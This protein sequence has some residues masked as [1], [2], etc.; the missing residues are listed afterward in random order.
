ML[1]MMLSLML[2]WQ[3]VML[4]IC[5]TRNFVSLRF[6]SFQEFC[7]L[8]VITPDHHTSSTSQSCRRH[9]TRSWCTELRQIRNETNI[10]PTWNTVKHLY[11]LFIIYLESCIHVCV[12]V[13]YLHQ[14]LFKTQCLGGRT[15]VLSFGFEP[16]A[17]VGVVQL[18]QLFVTGKIWA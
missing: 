4:T 11:N 5:A 14:N 7:V 13:T 9:L 17:E 8:T 10:K 1:S 18:H 16:S 6:A 2:E 15:D 12:C 3:W